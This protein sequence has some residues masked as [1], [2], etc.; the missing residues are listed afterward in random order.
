MSE[1]IPNHDDKQQQ[2]RNYYVL[3]YPLYAANG[4]PTGALQF[5]VIPK[6]ACIPEI[7]ETLEVNMGWRLVAEQLGHGSK[8]DVVLPPLAPAWLSEG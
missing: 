4:Q 5:A 6:W 1:K 3:R 7:F 8:P 2:P